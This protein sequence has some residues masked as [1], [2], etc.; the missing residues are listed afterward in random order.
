MSWCTR[1]GGQGHIALRGRVDGEPHVLAVQPDP[2]ARCELLPDHP[3]PVYFEHPRGGESAHQGG[4]DGNG[5]RPGGLDQAQ[6][7][8]NRL[9]RDPGDDLVPRTERSNSCR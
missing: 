6:R 2:E 5:I 8:G 4:L 1:F 9:D 3:W 7:F